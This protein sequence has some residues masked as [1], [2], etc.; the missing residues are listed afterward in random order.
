MKYIRNNE[1]VYSGVS[2]RTEAAAVGEGASLA[3]LGS[4]YRHMLEIWAWSW[5]SASKIRPSYT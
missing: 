5:L 4:K 1:N 2:A 3:W